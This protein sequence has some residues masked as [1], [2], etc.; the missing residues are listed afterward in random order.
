[1]QIHLSHGPGDIL[2]FM[3]VNVVIVI[4]VIIR[5]TTAILVYAVSHV[6]P[7]AHVGTVNVVINLSLLLLYPEIVSHG[8]AIVTLC[9]SYM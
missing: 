7:N 2:I 3:T 6:L 4:F 9:M 1:M 8:T 5:I